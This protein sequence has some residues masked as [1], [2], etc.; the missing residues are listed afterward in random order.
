MPVK[1]LGSRS[2]LRRLII[3][4]G[5]LLIGAFASSSAYDIWRSY[6]QST[7]ATGGELA[8]LSGALA[9]DAAQVFQSVDTMLRESAAWY[10]RNDDSVAPEVA[11]ETLAR[12]ALGLP[13]LSL[14]VRDATGILRYSWGES[15]A[16]IKDHAYP[17]RLNANQDGATQ[18]ARDG[19]AVTLDERGR[20]ALIRQVRENERFTGTVS[21]LIDLDD[22]NRFY[23]AIEF[24][25]GNTIVLLSET[26]VLLARQPPADPAIAKA[27]PELVA[28]GKQGAARNRKPQIVISQIDGNRQ[29]VSVSRVR[30]YPFWLTVTREEGV[31]LAPWSEQT[32]HAAIRTILLSMLAAFLIA[33]LVQQLARLDAAE[34]EQQRL[35]AQLRQSQKMEAMGT[36]AGGIAHDFNNILGAILGYSELAQRDVAEG[37][38]VR[39]YL[40]QVVHAGARAKRLVEG[41]LAFSRSGL[42]ERVPVD[43][44]G[45]VEEALELLVASLPAHVRLDKKLE[46]GGAA[47]VGDPTQLHQV[48]MNLCTNAVQAMEQGGMLMVRL[49]QVPMHERRVLSHGTLSPGVY[50]RLTVSDTGSGIPPVVLERIFDPFFTTKGVGE[51]TGLGLS[52]VHGIA[53]DLG[54]A[55]DVTT[56][57]GAG[58]TF[59]IWLPASREAATAF[60]RATHELPRG[61][62]EAIMIVDDERALVM[63]SEETLAQLGYEPTGFESSVAALKAFR[64]DPG[65]FDVVITDETMPDMTGIELAREIRRMRPDIP[66]ILMSGYSGTQL[67]ERAHA[68]G[69]GEILRKPLESRDLA[70]ALARALFDRS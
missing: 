27:F 7:A 15:T 25:A 11:R 4:G 14:A 42:G 44:Q 37:S 2:R 8:T 31:A 36:L 5:T 51:G 49:E 40:D 63:L 68:A 54:G 28:I 32:M 33:L 23:A 24:G 47:V 35:Q 1:P 9:E 21:A 20:P 10:R 61:N 59:V 26:G 13:V 6:V 16:A 17:N 30:G 43:V 45:I 46:A 39:R 57:I 12:Y 64:D 69:I 52:L 53:A 29:F 55:I 48:V 62:G 66:V 60:A 56:K 50:V 67:A 22:F 18:A 38:P 58:T 34:A 19:S 70:D 65:R 3:V 41:I